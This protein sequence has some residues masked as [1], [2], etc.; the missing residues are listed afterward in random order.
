[1]EAKR[2]EESLIQY[3]FK[4]L[5]G[6]TQAGFQGFLTLFGMTRLLFVQDAF[7]QDRIARILNVV[8]EIH[9]LSMLSPALQ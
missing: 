1:M 6:K 5:R 9:A 3:V 8:T 7:D 4:C 2:S